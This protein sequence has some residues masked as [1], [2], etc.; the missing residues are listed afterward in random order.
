MLIAA[1]AKVVDREPG[2]FTIGVYKNVLVAVWY[3]QATGNALARLGQAIAELR[4]QYPAGRSSIHV[5][6][7]GAP[8]PTPEAQEAFVRL[9]AQQDLACVA[10]VFLGSGFWASSL[11]SNGI[12]ITQEADAKF[13]MRQHDAIEPLADWLPEAH[14]KRTG[15]AIDGETLCRVVR[16]FVDG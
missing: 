8:P 12:S 16:A 1:G 6:A 14:A 13:V 9:A 4:E 5:V 15:V 7:K 3:Q 11:R 2:S 10:G